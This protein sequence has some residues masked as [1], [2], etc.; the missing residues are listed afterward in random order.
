MLGHASAAYGVI[1][2]VACCDQCT[3]ETVGGCTQGC[4]TFCDVVYEVANGVDLWVNHFVHGDEVGAGYVPVC[5]LQGK[6]QFVEVVQ[7]SL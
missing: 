2:V 1:L 5:V 7:A 6:M 4:H 3:G